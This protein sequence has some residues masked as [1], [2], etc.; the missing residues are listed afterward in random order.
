VVWN[1]GVLL[2]FGAAGV[3]SFWRGRERCPLALMLR[4][5][6]SLNDLA[7]RN[8]VKSPFWG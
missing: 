8:G 5:L 3:D 1:E 7:N 6:S 2:R 4:P